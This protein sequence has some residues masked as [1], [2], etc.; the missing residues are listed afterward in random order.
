MIKINQIKLKVNHTESQLFQVI[1]QTLRIKDTEVKEWYI[2]KQSIDARKKPNIFYI[3]SVCVTVANE[4]A[5]MKKLSKQKNNQVQQVFPKKYTYIPQGTETLSDAPVVI[6]SG[7][8]GLFCAYELAVQGYC[9]ILVERGAPVEERIQDVEHFWETGELKLESNVQF[10]EG[11][12]GTFSDGKL[13]TGVK[14]S[15]GR[16]R[17]VLETLVEHGAPK[18]I[19]Y[20]SKPHIGTDILV[21]VVRNIRNHILALGGTVRFHSKV[22]ALQIHENQL[23]GVFINQNEEIRTNVAV[24]A[25]GHSARD[26]FEYLYETGIPMEAKSFA[27]GVRVEHPQETIN[28]SQYGDNYPPQLPAS[29]YK[30]TANLSAGRG[31]YSFCM[32]PGGHVV[33]A[34]S[35]SGM[36]AVNGMSYSKRDSKNANSAIVV[37]INPADYGGE[38]PLAGMY[39]QRELERKAFEAGRGKIPVQLY[40]DFCKNI[41][42]SELKSIIP[43]IK[44]KYFPTN[45]RQILPTFVGDAIEEGMKV[46]GNKIRGFSD[47]DVVL[48]GV[49]SRTSSPIRILRNQGLESEVQ[50]LYPCGEG[51]G[52]A[53]GITSAAIDGIKVSEAIGNRY[54]ATKVDETFTKN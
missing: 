26:T 6:G 41:P 30:L 46:F 11:G 37:T 48:S 7:P 43:E 10:G 35:E 40:D 31:V 9:P 25:I 21:D 34:S 18:D 36:L 12:A 2:E 28:I 32:C 29:P 47:P 23:Q 53:G 42:S 14:D 39:F 17:R 8:A 3:Y 5:L 44:G 24:L 15:T 50:G 4:P 13:N 45:V 27:I 16:N 52:Y 33:D 22:T 1:L 54:Q 38:E 49:E 51:A 20:D 19:L